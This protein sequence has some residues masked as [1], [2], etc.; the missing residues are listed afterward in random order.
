[1][2]CEGIFTAFKYIESI[3]P[4]KIISRFELDFY[5]QDT[6]VVSY[7]ITTTHFRVQSA[8]SVNAENGLCGG[9]T[10]PLVERPIGI[11]V[12]FTKKPQHH[13]F[14]NYEFIHMVKPVIP[15]LTTVVAV[16]SVYGR[17]ARIATTDRCSAEILTIR[18]ICANYVSLEKD[19]QGNQSYQQ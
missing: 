4:Q 18:A 16:C 13:G 3:H 9:F 6:V 15:S 10:V 14:L 7:N 17:V 11:M 8:F 1:M 2:Y 12:S 5:V 19:S